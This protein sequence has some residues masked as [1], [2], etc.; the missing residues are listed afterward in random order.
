MPSVQRLGQYLVYL[1]VRITICV[2]QALPLSVC[3]QG[4]RGLA[5]LF[6]DVLR[7][8][9]RVT[10]E[11]LAHAFP[12][13]DAAQRRQLARQMWEHL[14]LFAAE[15][16][17]TRRKIHRTNW[18]QYLRLEGEAEFV[19][20]L[21]GDRPVL[22]VTAHFGNF[23]LAGYFFALCGYPI[24][25]VARPLDNPYLD[26]FV[27]RFRG[28]TGQIMLSKQGD[29][30]RICSILAAGGTVSFVADQYAGAKGCW[31]EF[32]GRPASAHKAIALFALD[33]NAP[34]AVGRCQRGGGPL[35]YCLKLQ[36]IADPR[37]AGSEVESIRA[38]TAWYH[39]RFEEFIRQ[40]PQQYWWLHR[41]WKDHR[42]RKPHAAPRA[43][44]A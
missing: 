33:N 11:N 5:W 17:H 39:A 14:F 8:R 22:L 6:H 27:N 4:A 26:R 35:Q 43:R 42:R 44:A 41:R 16:A 25:T 30:D 1:A 12:Q 23:E 36:G 9:R 24:H 21:L 18:H 3:A 31:I 19:R 34:M 38:L 40:A 20:L 7:V 15:V 28:S 10:D 13:L 32:F 2:V 29:Y 37:A